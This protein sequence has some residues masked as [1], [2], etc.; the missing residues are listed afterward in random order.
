MFTAIKAL[1]LDA[2]AKV[3]LSL[4]VLGKRP[5]GYHDLRSVVVPVALA[6]RVELALTGV[7]IELIVD[8]EPEIDLARL[9]A[10]EQNLAYRAARLL[11]ARHGAPA[12]IRIAIR[13]RIPIGGGLG[14]GSAD[15]AAVL[16]GINRLCQLGLSSAALQTLGAEL[17]SD[18]PAMLY[19]GAVCMEGRG[20][21]VSAI[22]DGV[23]RPVPGFWLV[24]A[25][26]GICIPTCEA[27]RKCICTGGLTERPNCYN[28]MV[29]SVRSGDVY[30]AA[31][32]LFNG[33]EPGVFAVYP[34]TA[35]LAVRLRDAG[36]LGVI[37][38]GSGASVFALVRD[39]DHG[40]E[41]RRR[42]GAGVW[43]KLTKTLPDGVMVAHGPLEP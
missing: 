9:G 3:N 34:E 33:L 41:V 1:V 16:S 27:Y 5:D 2:P 39:E 24:L 20:E 31:A 40:E 25:N 6:D 7:D 35:S 13:K 29:S 14:G 32:S 38:S 11:Q 8:A 15:A 42:L 21:R 43:S 37:M 30:G 10:Q 4:E 23:P 12:G 26:P 22:L 36:G 17:G 18:I 19:G 28:F